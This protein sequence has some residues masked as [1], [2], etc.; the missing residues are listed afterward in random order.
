M[1]ELGTSHS[2]TT[3]SLEV[4]SSYGIPFV[5]MEMASIRAHLAD[6]LPWDLT[7]RRGSKSD[8]ARPRT[9]AA[10][11]SRVCETGQGSFGRLVTKPGNELRQERI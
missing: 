5:G 11:A 1:A 10:G 4:V 2:Q 7:D 6:C 3:S 8:K 9:G